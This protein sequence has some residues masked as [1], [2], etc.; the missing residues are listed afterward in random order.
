MTIH[1]PECTVCDKLRLTQAQEADR[2]LRADLVARLDKCEPFDYE[3]ALREL[4]HMNP[5]LVNEALTEVG[6]SA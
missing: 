5:D 1:D 6:V 2:R 4:A 3:A